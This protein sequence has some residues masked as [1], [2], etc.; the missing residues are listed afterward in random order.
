MFKLVLCVECCICLKLAG[1]M[2]KNRQHWDQF[3]YINP[4]WNMNWKKA[5]DAVYK[6]CLWVVCVSMFI[7]I[8][9]YNAF[10]R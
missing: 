6:K 2:E 8:H 3:Y 7:P 4:F 9:E 10:A 1:V 5:R